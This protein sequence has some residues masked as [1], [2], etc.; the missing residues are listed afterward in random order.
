MAVGLLR[1]L[2]AAMNGGDRTPP[3]VDEAGEATGEGVSAAWFD[4]AFP[5]LSARHEPVSEPLD[6]PA[7]SLWC[8]KDQLVQ[9]IEKIDKVT[10]RLY[11]RLTEVESAAQVAKVYH[12]FDTTEADTLASRLSA[13][14]HSLFEV[15]AAVSVFA[16]DEMALEE[17]SAPGF[18][19]EHPGRR[20]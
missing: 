2:A 3:R 19:E 11:G 10:A 13:I 7:Q 16:Q 14:Q 9:E 8:A 12:P 1:E 6:T 17:E 5:P 18:A 20:Q 15:R 4:R